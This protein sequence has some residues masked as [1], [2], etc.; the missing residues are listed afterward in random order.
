MPF[1]RSNLLL[2]TGMMPKII[3]GAVA[4]IRKRLFRR[5]YMCIL[6]VFATDSEK[7]TYENRLFPKNIRA[8]SLPGAFFDENARIKTAFFRISYVHDCRRGGEQ[9]AARG[10]RTATRTTLRP[11]LE[12][13]YLKKFNFS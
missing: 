12:T 10:S 3:V 11:S 1:S 13:V 4:Y 5:I 9:Q 8:Q 2:K 6:A 7:C